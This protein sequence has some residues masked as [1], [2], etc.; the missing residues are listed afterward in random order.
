[1]NTNR[2]YREV[3]TGSFPEDVYTVASDW[4]AEIA[5]N[6]FKILSAIFG[7]IVFMWLVNITVGPGFNL[8]FFILKRFEFGKQINSLLRV[9]TLLFDPLIETLSIRIE[10]MDR[11]YQIHKRLD[12]L[13]I[14]Q[15]LAI[16]G[17][18]GLIKG[19]KY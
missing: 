19:L 7:F 18:S 8:I 9:L 13:I 1:M 16:R 10:V 6:L 12:F 11:I 14:A 2:W 15:K 5:F 17:R 4:N 3:G